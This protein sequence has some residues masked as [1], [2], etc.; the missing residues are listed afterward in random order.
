[1]KGYSLKQFG[2]SLSY[3]RIEKLGDRLEPISNLINWGEFR[4]FLE[5]E[6]SK[7]GRPA[8]DPILMLKMLVI[9]S[10]YGVSDEELEYQ[11]ADRISFQKFLGFQNEIPDY[12]T[13]W[14]FREALAEDNI[15]DKIWEELHR[16]MKEHGIK[17]SKG[18][19]KDAAF[20]IAAPG[21]TNSG[22]KG[23]GKGQPST[24]NEDGSWVK[25]GEKSYF[26]YKKHIKT[27]LRTGIIKEV[28]VTTARTA[29]C[30]IDLTKPDEIVYRDRG[31]S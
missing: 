16:Q 7:V 13:V 18:V 25:K 17:F 4:K 5:R 12:T 28:A 27:D 3:E 10:W 9:Q 11:V 24:R 15:L 20:V 23:R 1:M 22:M 30:S 14:R 6:D 31:Y 29:D 19:M 2:T 8:Y 26:G 21:K